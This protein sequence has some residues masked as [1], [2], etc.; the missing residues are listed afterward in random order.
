MCISS[1]EFSIEFL[2]RALKSDIQSNDLYLRYA[3]SQR[4]CGDY[5]DSIN[6]FQNLL[7]NLPSNLAKGDIRFQIV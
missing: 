3:I 5:K 7:N 6:R 2:G 1:F 4:T